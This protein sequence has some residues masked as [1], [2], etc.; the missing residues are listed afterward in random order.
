MLL[1]TTGT[2]AFC[3]GDSG[4]PVVNANNELVGIVTFGR[5]D[6]KP[7][8]KT[9]KLEPLGCDDMSTRN[10]FLVLPYFAEWIDWAVKQFEP[11]ESKEQ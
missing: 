1:D 4:G 3:G 9:W 5:T 6:E 11:Q 10:G 8:P 7:H 2:Y